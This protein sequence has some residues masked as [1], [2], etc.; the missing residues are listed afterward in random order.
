MRNPF[1]GLFPHGYLFHI[2]TVPHTESQVYFIQLGQNQTR[3]VALSYLLLWSNGSVSPQYPV[4]LYLP[5]YHISLDDCL[6]VSISPRMETR[7]TEMDHR[8]IQ[9][10]IPPHTHTSYILSSIPAAV[11]SG[12]FRKPTTLLYLKAQE[13]SNRH[14]PHIQIKNKVVLN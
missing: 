7:V 5:A 1:W 2:K 14:M 12:C 11:T 9:D 4:S 3:M 6:W 8:K 13:N 10:Q